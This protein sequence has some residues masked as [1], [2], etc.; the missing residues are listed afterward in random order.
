MRARDWLAGHLEDPLAGFPR[1]DEELLSLITQLVMSSEREPGSREAMELNL[2]G[3]TFGV[4][5]WPPALKLP[6][7]GRIGAR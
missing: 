1:E 4:D 2:L 5:P 3:L 7:A 6:L